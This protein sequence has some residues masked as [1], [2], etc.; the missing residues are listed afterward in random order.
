[1]YRFRTASGT[2]HIVICMI[3]VCVVFYFIYVLSVCVFD[4]VFSAQQ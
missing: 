2:A 3:C 4:S 1:M